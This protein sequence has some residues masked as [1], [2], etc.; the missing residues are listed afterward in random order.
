[1]NEYDSPSQIFFVPCMIYPRKHF[2]SVLHAL[3][4]PL[5]PS[6]FSSLSLSIVRENEMVR[7]G[8]EIFADS[9]EGVF[10]LRGFF[11]FLKD[12]SSKRVI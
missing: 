3:P 2:K 5:P 8:L 11:F 12:E 6:C 7:N 10:L 1:M 4:L 9:F